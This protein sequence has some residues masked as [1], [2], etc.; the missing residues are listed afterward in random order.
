MSDFIPQDSTAPHTPDHEA[1]RLL[2]IST[3]LAAFERDLGIGSAEIRIGESS[4][5][6]RPKRVHWSRTSRTIRMALTAAACLVVSVIAWMISA[7]RTIAPIDVVDAPVAPA[8][9]SVPQPPLLHAAI[10]P[11]VAPVVHQV[12]ALFRGDADAEGRCPDCWC[13]AQWSPNWGEGRG[14]NDLHEDELVQAS[15]NHA[16]VT[17]P[18]RVVIVGLTGP[19]TAM[20]KSEAEALEMSLCLLKKQSAQFPVSIVD[21]TS[22][23]CLPAGVDYC[24]TTWDK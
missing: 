15:L 18:Q 22:A 1:E 19:A 24:M 3:D 10:A 7:E 16:C 20:P 23:Y 12:V 9:P 5:L 6:R 11:P 4:Q 13:V 21:N 8:P 14:T 2:R 17:D